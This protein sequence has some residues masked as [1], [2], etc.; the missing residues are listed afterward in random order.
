M[1]FFE[2][3]NDEMK[4]MDQSQQSPLSGCMG[5]LFLISSLLVSWLLWSMVSAGNREWHIIAGAV[6]FSVI[7][8]VLFYKLVFKKLFK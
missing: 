6:I 2:E 7:T 5:N 4:Q 1:G 3:L 8:L